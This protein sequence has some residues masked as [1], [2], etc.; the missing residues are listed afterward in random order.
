M[1]SDDDSGDM[2]QKGNRNEGSL[3]GPPVGVNPFLEIPQ[4][5][6]TVEYKKGYVMRK[7]C[8]DSNNKK[9]K[10]ELNTSK[11]SSR[12]INFVFLLLYDDKFIALIKLVIVIALLIF[13]LVMD[14]K[15]NSFFM[16]EI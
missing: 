8:Y 9:S 6:S 2:N 10:S 3:Q 13:Y 4:N 11:I 5:I 1:F 16:M 14:I 15:F 7:C 12:Q